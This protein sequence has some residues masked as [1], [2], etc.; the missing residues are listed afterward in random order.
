MSVVVV[1]DVLLDVDLLGTADR[2]SPDAPV[3]VV[4]VADAVRRP[5]GAGLVALML[6]R[7]GHH[8]RLVT[9]LSDD[10]RVDELRAALGPVEV[11]AGRSG[12]PTPVKTR[13]RAAGQSVVRVDEGCAP[14]PAPEVT[15]AMLEA[16]Q[17]ADV[18]VAADYGRGLLADDRLRD[19]LEHR[20]AGVPLVWD[21]HVRGADPVPG[22]TVVT[23]NLAEAAAAVRRPRP[24]RRRCCARGG[25]PRR[26]SSPS[27][28][29]ERSCCTAPRRSC[30]RPRGRS[31][32]TRAAPA[33]GW[34][35][36]SPPSCSPGPSCPGRSTPRCARRPGSWPRAGW[37]P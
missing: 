27:A 2:L 24:A 35:R 37:L 9:V 17:D 10:S 11:V 12:A 16:V 36:R 33:T 6:A 34:R 1:G 30:C 3:P 19:A 18:V 32:T 15:R 22:A 7:D 23:P 26:W 13:V 8:V 31:R 28:S 14:A 4:D 5:G 21:P 29:T 20:R 25:P